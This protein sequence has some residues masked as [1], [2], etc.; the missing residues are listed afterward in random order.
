MKIFAALFFS[1]RYWTEEAQRR[2]AAEEIRARLRADTCE[3]VLDGNLPS[4]ELCE[5]CD[6]LIAIPMSGSVQPHLREMSRR[7][8][9]VLLFAAYVRGNYSDALCD[10][11]LCRN[12]APTVMD[13]YGVLR[14]ETDVR[15]IR[16]RA[17]LE[18]QLHLLAACDTVRRGRI[19]MVGEPE[20]WVISVSRAYAVY[21]DRLGITVETVPPEE[22]IALYESVTSEEAQPIT[23]Y[24]SAARQ[25]IEPTREDIVR[26]ARMS[27][28]M[29]RL[30]IGH[31]ADGMAIACFS[32]I[33]RLG[34]NPCLGVSYL[35][36]ETPYFAACEGDIDSA[37]TMLMM[38]ALGAENPFMANPC[39]QADDTVNFAHCTAPLRVRGTLHDFVLRNHHETGV[40]A[41]P[42]VEY[43]TG[44]P[45]CMLR[46]AGETGAMMIER[47]V[48]VRGRY[49]PNCRT[50][51]CVRPENYDRWLNHIQGCH[52]VIAFGD[53]AEDA[54]ALCALLGV[55]VL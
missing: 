29:E 24:F 39:L 54:A 17:A 38:R 55:R 18:R 23:E 20:P 41:S 16:D 13:C 14:R 10:G 51:L 44:L 35:N 22:L 3:V 46:Y 40:G 6:V 2:A 12:A 47:G 30:L 48:S 49:E 8:P 27:R 19:L 45:L 9:R 52:Q 43:G 34:V 32:L 53:I 21:R 36:G 5:G 26:C 31:H 28:A 7:F 42:Q 4:A 33:A 1:S 50:Q 15:L 25:C 37:V 11:M